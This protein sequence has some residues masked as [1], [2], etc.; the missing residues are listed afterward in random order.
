MTNGGLVPDEL[1]IELLSNKMTSITDREK[2][3][4]LDGFPRSV[5]QGP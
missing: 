3:F 1:T 5:G 4:L 2:G